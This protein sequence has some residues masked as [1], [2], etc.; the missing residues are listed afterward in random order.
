[1]KFRKKDTT[2]PTI[3]KF[4]QRNYAGLLQDLT[5]ITMTT[6]SV[7]N[8]NSKTVDLEIDISNVTGN[9]TD[10][11]GVFTSVDYNNADSSS[12]NLS[13][14]TGVRVNVASKS[15]TGDVDNLLL[16]ILWRVPAAPFHLEFVL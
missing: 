3:N 16:G 13:G 12:V 7:Y 9:P 14:F 8:T 6:D 4:D 1:M 10:N 15:K 5:D 2:P 11:P